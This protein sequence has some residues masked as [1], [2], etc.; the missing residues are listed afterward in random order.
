MSERH[1]LMH[2]LQASPPEV[3]IGLSRAGVT[4]VQKT[5]RIRH[6]EVEKLIAADLDCTVDL[7]PARKGVHMSRFPELFEDAIE[8]VVIGE[9]LLVEQLAERIAAEIIGRQR[10]LRAEVKIVARYPLE[11]T[12]P[13]TGLP[14]QEMISLVGIAAASAT[15]ARRL[16]GVEAAGINA[17][18]CA[19][20]LVREAAAER[21]E[22]AGFD[23]DD[24]ERILELVPVATHNQRGRGTLYVGTEQPVN[25]EQLVRIV[26]GSMSAPV[27][28]LLKRPDELHVVEQAHAHARFVEDSV[29]LALRATLMTYPELEDED[30]LLSR[31]VNLETIHSHDVLAE[32]F[33][34]VGELRAE[35]DEGTRPTGHTELREWLSAG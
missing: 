34:T 22:D 27:Y 7:D 33:G 18:P 15:S 11:R 10:A 9:A 24:V 31:Q 23:E 28:E 8:E 6:G 29:R 17:C 20:G 1:F 30:F 21:L 3:R 25:A 26:E 4:G 13:V 12:T 32:R 2:D 14:T 16:V 5:I 19:Q 35:L